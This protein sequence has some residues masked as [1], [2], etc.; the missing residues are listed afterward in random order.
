[1]IDNSLIE[2]DGKKYD[3]V[4]VIFKEDN[5]YVY[6]SNVEDD[7]DFFVRKEIQKEDGKNYLVG[8]ENEE[9]VFQAMQFFQEKHQ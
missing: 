5:K 1:M 6:L 3:V 8:L 9:E 4:D 7:N 2:I